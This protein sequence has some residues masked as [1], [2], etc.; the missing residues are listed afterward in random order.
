VFGAADRYLDPELA[1]HLAGLFR[2]ADLQLVEAAS[3][4]P[5]WDQPEMVAQVI[6]QAAPS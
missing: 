4:W 6:K 2:R 3:H 5:R 1:R